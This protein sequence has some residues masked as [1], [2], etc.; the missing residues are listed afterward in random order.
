MA[1]YRITYWHEIP[2]QVDVQGEDG[3]WRPQPLG[4]R[5]Q[6]LIDIVATKRGLFGTDDYLEGWQRGE[7]GT[8]PGSAVEVLA[9]LVAD[10]E[11]RFEG[12]RVSALAG[13]PG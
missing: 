8:A 10:L 4:A 2:S 3:E 5:F 6:E 7:I 1:S 9:T 11:A 13:R 12:I